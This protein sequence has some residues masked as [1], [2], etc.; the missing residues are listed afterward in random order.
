VALGATSVLDRY[1]GDLGGNETVEDDDEVR[2]ASISGVP[3][4]LCRR[5]F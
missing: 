4:A 1:A 5:T 3:S 2:D